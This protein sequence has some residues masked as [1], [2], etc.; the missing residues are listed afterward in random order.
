MASV[1]DRVIEI[2]SS[3][4]GVS[5]ENITAETSFISDLGADSLD[6]VELVMA[7]EEEFDLEI[8][9]NEAEKL[10]S[11]VDVI[12]YVEDCHSK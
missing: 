11:V 2:V 7:L 4:L 12:K 6:T 8:P 10:Q 3:Q 5:K 1:Q 9:D